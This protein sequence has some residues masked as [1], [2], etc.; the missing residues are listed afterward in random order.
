ME[1]PIVN[2]WEKNY[3]EK[4]RE[5]LYWHVDRSEIDN[6]KDFVRWFMQYSKGR[7]NPQMVAEAW[8]A[9]QNEGNVDQFRKVVD[10]HVANVHSPFYEK[11]VSEM[12]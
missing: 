8:D 6:K 4:H 1:R 3:A 10:H 11:I 2:M 12:C 5:W 9:K 7:I